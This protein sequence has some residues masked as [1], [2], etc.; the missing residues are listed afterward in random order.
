M[1]ALNGGFGRR[2]VGAA[3][4]DGVSHLLPV[5]GF[6]IA[7]A[8]GVPLVAVGVDEGEG[9]VRGPAGRREAAGGGGDG[10]SG[11][12]GGREGDEGERDG[13]GRIGRRRGHE[14]G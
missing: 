14:R 7:A 5:G 4:G 3:L 8:E 9:F 12:G 11:G 10:G 1:A 6:E 2:S 13:G